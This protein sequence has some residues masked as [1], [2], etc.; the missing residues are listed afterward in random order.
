M[1]K[2]FMWI[3]FELYDQASCGLVILQT[4]LS[5]ALSKYPEQDF[6]KVF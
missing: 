3:D 1:N 4:V 2:C 6:K 5:F